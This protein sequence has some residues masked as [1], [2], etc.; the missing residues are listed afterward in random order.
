MILVKIIN[1]FNKTYDFI[2]N[3]T[4]ANK[5]RK[6]VVYEESKKEKSALLTRTCP[7]GLVW[8]VRT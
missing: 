3:D 5:N 1:L 7:P 4:F 6:G 8:E 2:E